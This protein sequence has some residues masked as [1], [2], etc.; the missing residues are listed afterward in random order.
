MCEDWHTVGSQLGAI[1]E[2]GRM[3][4]RQISAGAVNVCMDW[5]LGCLHAENEVG[6]RK[7]VNRNS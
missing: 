2:I 6:Y 1:R 5:K 3:R 7:S 4:L